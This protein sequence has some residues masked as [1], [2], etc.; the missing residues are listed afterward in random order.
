VHNYLAAAAQYN[1]EEIEQFMQLQVQN[2]FFV[3]ADESY[4]TI[5]QLRQG[6]FTANGK[7]IDLTI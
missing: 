3:K 2:G 5:L 4:Q 6:I 1:E 7:T